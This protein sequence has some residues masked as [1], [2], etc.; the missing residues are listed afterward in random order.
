M[1]LKPFVWVLMKQHIEL[2]SSHHSLLQAPLHSSA[3][4]MG[5]KTKEEREYRTS[6]LIK[7]QALSVESPPCSAVVLG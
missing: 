3:L 2:E 4:C 7:D 5:K 1:H 6:H